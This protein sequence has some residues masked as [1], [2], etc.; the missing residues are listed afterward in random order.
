MFK[1]I[2]N[3]LNRITMYRL[4]LYYLI[5]LLVVGL[6]FAQIGHFGFGPAR[7]IISSGI[8]V[9]ACYVANLVFGRLFSTPTNSES[10]IISGLILAL[11]ITPSLSA[12]GITFALSASVI[13]MASK[14]LLTIR[15]VHLF[16][17]AAVGV[18]LAA[19]F[20]QISASWWIATPKMLPFVIIGGLLVVRK[21]QRSQMVGIFLVTALLATVIYTH[22]GGENVHDYL[23]NV[24][25]SSALFFMAFVMLTE[26]MTSPSTLSKQRIYAVAAGLLFPPQVHLASLYTT[27]QLDLILVNVLAYLIGPKLKILPKLI[28]KHNL[29]DNVSEFI[30]APDRNFNFRAGQYME[31]TLPHTKSDSRGNRRYFTIASSPTEKNLHLTVKFYPNGSSFKKKLLSLSPGQKIALSAAQLGGDFTL[32]EDPNQKLVFIAGGIGVTPYRSMV[33]YLI[34]TNQKRSVS[35]LYAVNNQ[36][37]LVYKSVFEQARQRLG[38]N[39]TYL[40]TNPVTTALPEHYLSGQIT[41]ELISQQIPDY[42]DRFY[43]ISGPHMMVE[44]TETSLRQAGVSSSKIKLDF[45]PGYA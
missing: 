31:W 34:D 29:T 22:I 23:H 40:L 45:F 37:D 9:G 4:L 10:S 19:L 6:W 28:D 18:F 5:A 7:L 25:L 41:P 20:S 30:F 13:A 15:K 42:K 21:I 8:L 11:I 17:P 26:P 38:I 44:A 39:T 12:A 2:D 16:N 14:Y 43:Y 24:L 36:T 1:P 32:P 27:P 35:V 33:Q 3:F